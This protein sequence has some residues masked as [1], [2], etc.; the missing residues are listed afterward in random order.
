MLIDRADRD[1][2]NAKWLIS[3]DGNPSNDELLNDMAAYHVQQG[4]EKALK[5]ALHTVCGLD[6]TYKGY[7]TH[8]IMTLINIVMD[9]SDLSVSE[10][11]M[12]AANDITGWEAHSRYDDSP[13]SV[14][15][16]IADAIDMY[17]E[18]TR[19]ILEKEK[20]ILESENKGK[21]ENTEN[22][23]NTNNTDNTGETP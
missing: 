21:A 22:I 16:D 20:D 4:I 23:D 8:D 12:D 6:E 14:R 19:Q 7:R 2:Y 9:H 18:L 13:V 1:I 15:K 3:S 5:H 17:E 10:R 11:L